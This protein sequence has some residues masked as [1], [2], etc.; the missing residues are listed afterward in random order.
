LPRRAAPPEQL[1]GEPLRALRARLELQREFLE[2]LEDKGGAAGRGVQRVSVEKRVQDER[3][4][5]HL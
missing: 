1:K 5:Y 3:F 2:T 4:V